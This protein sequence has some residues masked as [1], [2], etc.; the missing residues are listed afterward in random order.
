[1]FLP[2]L[3]PLPAY[4]VEWAGRLLI[5]RR[6]LISSYFCIIPVRSGIEHFSRNYAAALRFPACFSGGVSVLV[7]SSIGSV[8]PAAR[9]VPARV[10]LSVMSSV[11]AVCLLALSD[12]VIHR[13]HRFAFPLFAP[14]RLV[15]RPARRVVR[16]GAD[17]AAC[18]PR[19]VVARGVGVGVSMIWMSS[20]A[21]AYCRAS[22]VPSSLLLRIG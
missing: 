13:R 5:A 18:L 20:G 7:S 15:F 14:C 17:G 4:R 11:S 6:C 8:S 10:M 3:V 12:D 16:R 1:M 9:A 21:V 2:R 19:D 22:I